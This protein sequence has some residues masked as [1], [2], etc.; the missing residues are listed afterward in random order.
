M[1]YILDA[2][3]ITF[4]ES[5]NQFA[6]HVLKELRDA[7][8]TSEMDYDTKSVKSKMKKAIKLNPKYLIFIGED[9]VKII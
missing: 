7:N 3:I 5:F 4:D 9:E 6:S 8:I 2:Y 1:E